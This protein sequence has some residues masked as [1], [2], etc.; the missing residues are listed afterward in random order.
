[1]KPPLPFLSQYLTMMKSSDR[2]MSSLDVGRLVRG[3]NRGSLAG[4]VSLSAALGPRK[5]WNLNAH[6]S[7]DR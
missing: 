3:R 6:Q 2:G 4:F 5:V 1:M 7:G